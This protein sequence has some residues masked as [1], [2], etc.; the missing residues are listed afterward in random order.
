M[1]SCRRS[2][3]LR[4]VILRRLLALGLVAAILVLTPTANASPPDESWVTGLYDDDDFD[5]VVLFITS[6]FGAIES[7]ALWS[8]R[9]VASVLRLA[10]PMDTEPR[11]LFPLLS[12]LSRAPP[13]P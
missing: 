7:S 12:V 1:R 3:K 6:N 9:L 10:M 4:R 13:L 2:L 11:P 5:D 8:L